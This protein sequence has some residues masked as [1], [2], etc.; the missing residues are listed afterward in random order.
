MKS[1]SGSECSK[2]HDRIIAC[3]AA[4][5]AFSSPLDTFRQNRLL[6]R[7]VTLGKFAKGAI[8]AYCASFC[9]AYPCHKVMA[10]CTE[11]LDLKS[12]APVIFG[13]LV[14]NVVKTPILI[15]HKSIQTGLSLSKKISSNVKDV[16]KIS[17]VEDV[18][19]ESAKYAFARH[20]MESFTTDTSN[21]LL[22]CCLQAAALFCISYPF[23]IQ[24]NMRFY[25]SRNLQVSSHDFVLKA[26][27]KN[28]Q[29]AIFFT[30]VSGNSE[31]I[32][33]K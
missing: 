16:I 10:F 25:S 24:K 5:Y 12:C 3:K 6:S 13:V 31:S 15:N 1:S 8:S 29:N 17:V 14:A 22:V 30:M 18:I 19:E 20:N 2:E 21:K 4:S 28:V 32:M 9:I 7:S 26:L 33:E 27:Q 23:D 11:H